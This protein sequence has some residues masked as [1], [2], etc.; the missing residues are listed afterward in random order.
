MVFACL[1]GCGRIGFDGPPV[2]ST[3]KDAATIDA[4]PAVYTPFTDPTAWTTFD[5]ASLVAGA[6][7]FVGAVFDGHY[8]Y[9]VPSYN[10]TLN[11]LVMRL[12]TQG[13]FTDLASWSTFDT[14]TIAPTLRGFNGGVFDGRYVY[15]VPH[16]NLAGF[17][18]V[19]TRYDTQ[20][21]FA[22]PAAWELFDT[23]TIDPGAGGFYGARFDG[24]YI[25]LLPYVGSVLARYDTQGTFT[26]SSGWTKYDL[27]AVTA[28]VPAFVG[29]TFDGRY[30]YLVPFVEASPSGKVL[31]YDTQASLTAAASW[32]TF[33]TTTKTANA[34]GFCGGA[35]DGRYLY[36]VPYLSAGG[37]PGG[38]VTRYDTQAAFTA[39]ASWSTF[40]ATSLASNAKGFFGA[41]FDGRYVYLAPDVYGTAVRYDTTAPFTTAAAWS[42]FESTSVDPKAQGF[43]GAAFDGGAVY[44]IPHT[45]GTVARF[46]A[47]TPPSMPQLPGFDGSFL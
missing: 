12:D 43:Y 39:G 47:K 9:L 8:L 32:T 34:K 19:I 28:S 3:T 45:G 24:R 44:F 41:T 25:Y 2:D 40:D 21:P 37:T 18:G 14:T 35:F 11:G 13:S 15:F 26:T 5:A 46:A 31:R 4:G 22:S 36:L 27:T 33:D 29:G 17:D 7:G 23:R 10:G 6:G 16:E 42:V 20:R 30:L 38:I 1:A